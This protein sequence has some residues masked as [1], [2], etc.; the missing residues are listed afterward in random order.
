[1]GESFLPSNEDFEENGQFYFWF[2]ALFING[3]CYV[4]AWQALV[5]AYSYDRVTRVSPIF[6]VET[7]IVMLCDVFVFRV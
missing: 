4:C 6:Y 3:L 1:M 2:L 7:A 5:A